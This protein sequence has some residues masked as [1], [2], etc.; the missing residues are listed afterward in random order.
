[1]INF[2]GFNNLGE[3]ERKRGRYIFFTASFTE[4]KDLYTCKYD[5]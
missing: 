1:M 2:I 5:F 3:K 4:K